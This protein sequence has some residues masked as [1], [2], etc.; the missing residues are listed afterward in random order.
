MLRGEGERDGGR[1]ANAAIWF[2]RWNARDKKREARCVNFRVKHS[3]RQD[4]KFIRRI[5]LRAR[6]SETGTSANAVVLMTLRFVHLDFQTR[7]FT[8]RGTDTVWEKRH[9]KAFALVNIDFETDEIPT[10]TARFNEFELSEEYPAPSYHEGDRKYVDGPAA[11]H[12][13]GYTSA[14]Y[15]DAGAVSIIYMEQTRTAGFMGVVRRRIRS[16]RDISGLNMIG[17]ALNPE[18]PDPVPRAR[19]ACSRMR[20]KWWNRGKLS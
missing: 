1:V 5:E 7:S 14:V 9:L 16:G 3:A 8:S 15:P 12:Q 20:A 10:D 11:L 2:V 4:A 19:Q 18:T 6:L 13:R 17:D